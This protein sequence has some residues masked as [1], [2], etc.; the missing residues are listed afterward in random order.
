MQEKDSKQFNPTAKNGTTYNDNK[1]YLL[2]QLP[3]STKV[4]TILKT[5]PLD[6]ETN[7]QVGNTHHGSA[8]QPYMGS[9]GGEGSEF[10]PDIETPGGAVMAGAA[11]H[12][13]EDDD[14]LN[15]IQPVGGGQ[16]F[17]PNSNANHNNI[18]KEVDAY[19]EYQV[20][21]FIVRLIVIRLSKY[22]IMFNQK[23]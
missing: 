16:G 11:M 6:P 7:I 1:A 17:Y 10:F 23:H 18:K 19:N 22:L 12:A 21:Q 8:A 13:L 4:Q 15:S 14:F 5:E 9:G 2:S 3:S 20:K